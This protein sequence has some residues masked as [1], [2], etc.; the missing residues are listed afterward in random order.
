MYTYVLAAGLLATAVGPGEPT[1]VAPPPRVAQAKRVVPRPTEYYGHVLAVDGQ[2]ITVRGSE[3]GRPGDELVIRRFVAGEYLANG[4]QDP[5]ERLNCDYRLGDI[6]VGDRVYL[7]L[8]EL[9]D[10]D[11]CA[12]VRIF[13]RPGGRVPPAPWDEPEPGRIPYHERMNAQQAFEE[14]GIPLPRRLDPNA[15]PTA[16]E[17]E[18]KR[19]NEEALA[20]LRWRWDHTAPPPRK[21]GARPSAKP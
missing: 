18:I 14:K 11:V 20:R 17:L 6:R 16:E 10:E 2:S 5:W 3:M 21:V 12:S 8:H 9:G 1:A 15:P 13:R 4:E 19:K 7:K